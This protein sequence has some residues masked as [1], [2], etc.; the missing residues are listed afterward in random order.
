VLLETQAVRADA[1]NLFKLA[2]TIWLA[3]IISNVGC[4]TVAP[5]PQLRR[6]YTENALFILDHDGAALFGG[7]PPT[8]E[9]LRTGGKPEL[10]EQIVGNLDGTNVVAANMLLSAL[11]V[12]EGKRIVRDLCNGFDKI[13][14]DTA[15]YYLNTILMISM[16]VKVATIE[17]PEKGYTIKYTLSR[18]D[19]DYVCSEEQSG[20]ASLGKELSEEE[21]NSIFRKRCQAYWRKRL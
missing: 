21:L 8:L 1:M 15:T 13:H 19:C 11:A 16:R 12:L 7:I 9:V 14:D 18:G 3:L 4:T 2:V 17:F 20:H 10:L 5:G 6:E